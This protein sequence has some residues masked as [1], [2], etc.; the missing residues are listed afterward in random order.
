MNCPEHTFKHAYW[1]ALMTKYLSAEKA[2]L[3]ATAHESETLKSEKEYLGFTERKHSLMD[4][5]GLL[6]P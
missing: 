4:I 1:N 5:L 6:T 3:F 2:G